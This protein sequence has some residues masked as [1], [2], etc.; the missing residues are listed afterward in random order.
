LLCCESATAQACELLQWLADRLPNCPLLVLGHDADPVHLDLFGAGARGYCPLHAEPATMRSTM[1]HL[2]G[3]AYSYPPA[4][5]AAIRRRLPQATAPVDLPMPSRLLCEFLV[6]VA[7]PDTPTYPEI[8]RRMGKSLPAVEQY[9]K[10]LFERYDIKAKGGL[11]LLA[12]R[13][14]LV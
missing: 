5:W 6:H 10:K 14:G 1:L 4:T 8:A 7:A 9:R 3:G 12:K 11:V 13:L 2:L